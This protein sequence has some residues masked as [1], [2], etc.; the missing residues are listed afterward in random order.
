MNG[1]GVHAAQHVLSGT[2]AVPLWWIQRKAPFAS[3]QFGEGPA[4]IDMSL[5]GHLFDT[6][7]SED[8]KGAVALISY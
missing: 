8:V 3:E 2:D 7:D 4:L 6:I 5:Q 1:V